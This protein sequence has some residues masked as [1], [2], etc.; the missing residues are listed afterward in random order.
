MSLTREQLDERLNY[1]CGS[2]AAVICGISPYNNKIQLWQEKTKQITP[3]DI[4]DKPCIKA[5][6]FL[7]PA[8]REWFE[9]E[10]GMKVTTDPRLLIHESIPY[11]A[12]HI[13]GWVGTD[14]IFE[15][16]TAAYDYGWGEQGDNIIPD[17]Y[18]CQVAHYMAV[19]DVNKAYVAVLIRGT[20]FRYYLIERNKK[21]EEMLLRTQSEFWNCVKKN[22]APT[23]TSGDE[24][25]SLHGYRS[26]S[27]SMVADG[28]INELLISLKDLRLNEANIAKNKK[29]IEDKIKVFMGEKDTLLDQNGKIAITWKGTASSKRFDANAFR[30]E[31]KDEYSKYIR[32]VSSSRRFLIKQQEGL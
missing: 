17:H 12:G 7:E 8:V 20:D 14:A 24:V 9:S 23:P 11:M 31:N 10:T 26:I 18:L 30:E 21:L 22:I 16:K 13:D 15:A 32:E 3:K 4:S 1:I 19:T 6:N 25:I 2:D 27:E 5:G 29:A 28:E